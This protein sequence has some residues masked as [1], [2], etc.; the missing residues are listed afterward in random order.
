MD[1]IP[2]VSDTATIRNA[3]GVGAKIVVVVVVVVEVGAEAGIEVEVGVV[4]EVGVAIGVSS[5]TTTDG[6]SSFTSRGE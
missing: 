2:C 6:V 4:G 1:S 5:A 3:G